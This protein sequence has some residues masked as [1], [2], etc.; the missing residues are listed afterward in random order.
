M[1]T[2]SVTPKPRKAFAAISP[3]GIIL[4]RTISSKENLAS[5]FCE[6]EYSTKSSPTW[7]DLYRA[8]YR[9]QPINIS[10]AYVP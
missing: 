10:V 6:E 3:D 2:E 9:V 1:E 4:L 5:T 8:G 7:N